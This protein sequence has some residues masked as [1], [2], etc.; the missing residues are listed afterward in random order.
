MH[1]SCQLS[2]ARRV[3]GGGAHLVESPWENRRI[4]RLEMLTDHWIKEHFILQY[5]TAAKV[6]LR[7]IASPIVLSKLVVILTTCP[8]FAGWL[9]IQAWVYISEC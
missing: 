5:I 6:E 1:F 3:G 2:H 4:W 8:N 7:G 9:D